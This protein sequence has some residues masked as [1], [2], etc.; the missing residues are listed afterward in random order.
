MLSW[1]V[2]YGQVQPDQALSYETPQEFYEEWTD[3]YPVEKEALSD[4]C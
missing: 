2:V 3:K 1:N 4:I